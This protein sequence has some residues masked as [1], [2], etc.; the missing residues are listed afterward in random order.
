MAKQFL[1]PIFS[2]FVIF[3]VMA[4]IIFGASSGIGLSTVDYF[5]KKTDMEV[6]GISRSNIPKSYI[7]SEK[8]N[9]FNYSKVDFNSPQELANNIKKYINTAKINVEALVLNAGVLNVAPAI[10]F[11]DADVVEMFNVNFF[12]HLYLTRALVPKMLRSGG[13][14][15][16]ISSSAAENSSEGRSIYNASKSA[17]ESYILTLGHEVGAKGIRANIVRPGLTD[18]SLMNDTTPE[19]GKKMFL[20]SSALKSICNPIDIANV[21]GFLVSPESKHISCA[22]IPVH[23]GARL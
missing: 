22:C 19:E 10:T 23:G 7:D 14:I 8:L 16:A 6:V 1:E 13:S 12:Y 9:W 4:V 11:R 15:V 21:I 17:L 3:D 20:E 18:T 2:F 5:L